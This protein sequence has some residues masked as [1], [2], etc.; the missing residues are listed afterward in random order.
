[1]SKEADIPKHISGLLKKLPRQSGVYRFYSEDKQLLYIG[2]AL[3]LRNRVRN[4]F[5]KSANH[6][7]KTKKMLEKINHIDWITTK[8]EL[9]AL[10]LEANLIHEHQPPFNILLRDD[11]HFL[12]LK[13]TKE[14][15]PRVLF[16]RKREKDKATYFGPYAKSGPVRKTVDFLRE[17]LRFRTCKVEIS[18]EGKTIR[19]PENRKIPCLDY[20]IQRCSGPCDTRIPLEE[21]NSNIN[22]MIEFLRGN[23]S[24]VK[25][26]LKKQ[27]LESAQG[28][29]FERAARFR[30]LLLYAENFETTQ[31]ASVPSDFSAD[32]IGTSFGVAKSFFAVLAVRNGKI[33]HSEN[34]SIDNAESND[35]TFFV[36]LR[37][38]FSILA[39]S[40]S[41]I[42]V[43]GALETNDFGI[44]EEYAERLFQK[45]TEVRKPQRGTGRSLMEFAEKNATLQAA[46]SRASFEK[47][48]VLEALQNSLSLPRTP[49]RIECYDISHLSG[50]HPVG[51]RVV[52]LDGKPAKGE[53]RKYKIR[54]LPSG[55]IDDFK[56]MAE[57]LGRRL[58]HLA[59][60]VPLL[61]KKTLK[62]K[63]EIETIE[64]RIE[65][66]GENLLGER[67]QQYLFYNSANGKEVGNAQIRK[68]GRS[69]MIA[70]VSVLPEFQEKGMEAEI[71]KTILLDSKE[72]S[73]RYLMPKKNIRLGLS[74][75]Q[76]GFSEE[77]KIPQAFQKAIDD[78]ANKKQEARLFSAS[79][80]KLKKAAK[81]IPDLLVIDGGKGQ[82]SAVEKVLKEL[83]LFEK[84]SVC[85][86]AKREEEIFV[87]GKKQ[88]LNIHKNA[89]ENQ[90]L[91][92]IR[93]EA[94]RF[95]VGFNRNLRKK[96]ETASVLDDIPGMGQQNKKALLQTFG[97]PKAVFEASEEEL[98]KVVSKKVVEAMKKGG[99]K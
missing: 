36:F 46:N 96:A 89:P 24:S 33:L 90:L 27:M 84:I 49:E 9:E 93:D 78:Y 11:K 7:P 17:V 54:S 16:V 75:A 14:P 80:E 26:M 64:A 18:P 70:G 82:L 98:L 25:R 73:L 53:Y 83:R 47:E 35:E 62:K 76:I 50:T 8:N 81:K 31:T 67:K 88:P 42:L 15:F 74:L 65:K 52:F 66:N 21:Y 51:S 99:E 55:D 68:V 41:R 97:S 60:H 13:I 59:E 71:C 57:V 6:S 34:F 37:D 56:A 92:Q 1:M 69:V 20:Q 28:K 39:E 79:P 72:K 86:L 58:K 87:P 95:A 94:H 91:Q 45:K 32:V 63:K 23:T 29:E 40:P 44:W 10:I 85:S 30:D 12:Y 3:D 48:D 2:K 38:Y 43:P 61:K 4:Y 5:Q 22:E 77:K 19:N